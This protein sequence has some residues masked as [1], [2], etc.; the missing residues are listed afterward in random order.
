MKSRQR[1]AFG[2]ARGWKV[3][4]GERF[5]PIEQFFGGMLSGC[6]NPNGKYRIFQ[7]VGCPYNPHYQRI[8]DFYNLYTPIT[9]IEHTKIRPLDSL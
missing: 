9:P 5:S 6:L 8:L 7:K 1:E 3:A 2:D 4:Q